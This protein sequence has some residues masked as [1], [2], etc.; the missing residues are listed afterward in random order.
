NHTGTLIRIKKDAI[1]REYF[2]IN[3]FGRYS[4]DESVTSLYEFTVHKLNTR[5]SKDPIKRTLA[6]T[7]NCLIERDPNSYSIICLKPLNEVFA[8][9]RSQTNLQQFSIEYIK[10][11]VVSYTSTDR[12]ALLASLLDGVRA[13]GNLDVHVKMSLTIRGNRIGPYSMP[14]DEEV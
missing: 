2:Q 6:L 1:T 13:S 9:I 5:N 7:E 12:D 3:K 11:Q 14:V 4:N 10:G 8:L